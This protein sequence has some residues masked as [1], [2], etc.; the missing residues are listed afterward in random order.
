MDTPTSGA[1]S[2][3]RLSDRSDQPQMACSR[4]RRQY[5]SRQVAHR[6]L[7][8]SSATSAC[9][10]AE[11]QIQSTVTQ[12]CNVPRSAAMFARNEHALPR[13]VFSVDQPT[14]SPKN[15]HEQHR[16]DK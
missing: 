7:I 4:G 15:R 3:T 12:V 11:P 14:P 16:A 13:D 5:L 10:V 2:S 1:I 8:Y 6:S 9:A